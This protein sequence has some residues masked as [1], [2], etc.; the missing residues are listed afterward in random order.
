MR[1]VH[2]ANIDLNL[3]V[4]FDALGGPMRGA[5]EKSALAEGGKRHPPAVAWAVATSTIDH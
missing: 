5:G 3:L 1:T 4:V 2:L